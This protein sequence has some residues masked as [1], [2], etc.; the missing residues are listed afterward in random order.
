M[1]F[2]RSFEIYC[3]PTL[4]L[5]VYEDFAT[6]LESS[7]DELVGVRKVFDEVG[8]VH[9]WH[10]NDLVCKFS[11]EPGGAYVGD[12]NDMG[13]LVCLHILLRL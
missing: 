5:P 10:S 11:G 9:I 8:F 13:N 3:I 12:L 2:A 7:I 4:L 1:G 6:A